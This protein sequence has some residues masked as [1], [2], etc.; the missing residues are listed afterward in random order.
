MGSY[1]SIADVK[2][3]TGL[4]CAVVVVVSHCIVITGASLPSTSNGSRCRC[5]AANGDNG[6]SCVPFG[7]VSDGVVIPTDE[8]CY[9]EV[10]EDSDICEFTE[11]PEKSCHKR[12][13]PT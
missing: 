6:M 12:G 11:S 3:C 7:D 1:Y 9:D 2:N 8:S 13:K 10:V 4:C 5:P